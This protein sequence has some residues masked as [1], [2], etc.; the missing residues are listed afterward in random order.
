MHLLP[1]PAHAAL[2]SQIVLLIGLVCKY[3]T[4]SN[5]L[6]PLSISNRFNADVRVRL[7]I[8]KW[9]LVSTPSVR[10]SKNIRHVFFYFPPNQEIT[11][12]H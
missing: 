3:N 10:S 7:R 6:A 8:G 5:N 9:K 4:R 12:I 1:Q 11:A 2:V